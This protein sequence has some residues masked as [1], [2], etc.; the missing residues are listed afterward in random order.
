MSNLSKETIEV[1]S[2]VISKVEDICAD[3]FNGIALDVALAS[4]VH[5]EIPNVIRDA[6]II[7][8]RMMA[9]TLINHA[10]VSLD[11]RVEKLERKVKVL[12]A[13]NDA[14]EKIINNLGDE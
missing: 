14:L 10:V 13:R 8:A 9:Y 12:Q 4:T 2:H 3:E 5:K 6:D 7:L 1:I 11:N